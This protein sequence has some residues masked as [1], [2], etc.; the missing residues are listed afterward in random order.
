MWFSAQPR[1]VEERLARLAGRGAADS[2][3][4]GQPAFPVQRLWTYLSLK[5][6]F[7]FQSEGREQRIFRP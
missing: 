7:N 3:P 6:N 4:R 2:A 1:A 5:E